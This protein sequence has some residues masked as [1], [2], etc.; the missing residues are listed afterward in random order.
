VLIASIL[1]FAMQAGFMCLEAGLVRQKNS[2]NVAIKNLSDF[3]ISSLAFF[4]IGFAFMFGTSQG[5]LIGTDGFFLSKYIAQDTE[6]WIF[7]FWFFQAVF[8]G[9]ATTIVAGG[10]AERVRYRSYL[11]VSLTVSMIIYPIFGHWVWGGGYDLSPTQGW[12]AA[13]GYKD[14]AGSSVVHMLGGTATLACLLIVGPR[15]GRYRPDGSV[16]PIWGSDLPQA[17]LGVFLLWIGWYGFNGGSALAMNATVVP[18]VVNTTLAASTGSL[19]T[20]AFTFL[21][22]GK[23]EVEVVLNGVLGGLVAITASCA[24]VSP[25]SALAI[26]MLGGLV[27]PIVEAMLHRFQIDDA[28]GAIPVHLGAGVV[29]ILSVALFADETFLVNGSRWQQLGVQAIGAAACFAFTFVVEYLLLWG[30]DRFVTP[31]RV[32]PEEEEMGLNLSEHGART[33]WSDLSSDIADIRQTQDLTGRV[34]VEPETEAGA[35]GQTFNDLMETLHIQHAE[36][37]QKKSELEN[38]NTQLFDLNRKLL[39]KEKENEMF[40]YGVSH[41]LRSPLVNIVGFSKEV[42]LSGGSL[43]G[44]IEQSSLSPMEKKRGVDLIDD[45]IEASLRFIHDAVARMSRMTDGLLR[46]SRIGSVEY[47]SREIDVDAL[48]SQIVRAMRET[49]KERGATVQIDPLPRLWGDPNAVEQLFSNLISNAVNYLDP[50]ARTGQVEVGCRS[51]SDPEEGKKFHHLYVK[52][53]GLGIPES[54]KSRLFRIFQRFHP[55][56]AAGTGLGLLIVQRIVE[57]HNGAV[58]IDSTEGVGT[59]VW[60]HWPVNAEVPQKTADTSGPF[61]ASNRVVS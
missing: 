53:N 46:L 13:I 10:I 32:T 57:R 40:V 22:H 16:V 11:W 20:M 50:S 58:R 23:P 6:G 47:Q 44:L 42:A 34:R 33:L 37:T 26:G 48:V 4:C 49:F 25:L 45:G 7:P 36:V 21:R 56:R 18:I 39:Q 27:V 9:T 54:S 43:R 51:P 8:C 5:G 28:V 24:W 38:A 60:I 30:F 17:T 12:L 61:F 19:A 29:G 55:D 52:D 1:V 35:V 41:D 15:K 3:L 59:T 2:I 14:F 31:L